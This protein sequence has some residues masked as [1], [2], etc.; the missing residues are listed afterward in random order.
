M[1]DHKKS[2]RIQIGVNFGVGKRIDIDPFQ[3]DEGEPIKK[4]ER[5]NHT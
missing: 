2:M 3:D 4:K 5:K 1:L